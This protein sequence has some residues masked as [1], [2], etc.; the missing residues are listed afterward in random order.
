MATNW[1]KEKLVASQVGWQD[2]GLT[3]LLGKLENWKASHPMEGSSAF[4]TPY[5]R[6]LFSEVSSGTKSCVYCNNKYHKSQECNKF[7]TL[8]ER[9]QKLQA[10]ELC[11][12]CTGAGHHAAHCR[13]RV[14]CFHCSKK[15]HSSICNTL[16]KSPNN[17]PPGQTAVT[18]MHEDQRVCHP[19]F[20]FVLTNNVTCREF[21][22]GATTPYASAY[23]LS[24]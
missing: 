2:W 14:T 1:I 8:V 4:K 12:N 13:R 11:F 5:N 15:H 17:D 24:L 3:E 18:A 21:G 19:S 23:F 6:F 9:R 7:V 10:K 22:T 16:E 20:F